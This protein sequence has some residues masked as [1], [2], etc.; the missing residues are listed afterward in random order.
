MKGRLAGRPFG[1]FEANDEISNTTNELQLQRLKRVG[2]F[3][4]R[5][6]LIAGLHW[7][8]VE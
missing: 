8:E 5:A 4:L 2:V 7:G 3:G 1:A 6:N